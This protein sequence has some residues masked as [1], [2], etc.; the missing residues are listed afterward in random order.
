MRS[1]FAIFLAVCFAPTIAHGDDKKEAVAKV[2][3][4]DL[5]REPE[6][7]AGRIVQIEGIVEETPTARSG[8]VLR[9]ERAALSIICDGKPD[10]AA[11]DRVRITAICEYGGNPSKLKL[12]A[13]IVEKIVGNESAIPVTFAELLAEPKKFDGKLISLDGVLRNSPEAIEF[14][15]EFRY[16]VRIS[17]GVA[18]TCHGKPT[19]V[20]GERVR[21][22]GTLTYSDHSFTPLLLDANAVEVIPR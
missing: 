17:A 16:S 2:Q 8:S 1:T 4:A 3:V 12:L 13:T 15:G 10:V 21:V 18:I 6:K 22:F 9:L 5:N 19:A 14:N 20:K 11:G 7:F